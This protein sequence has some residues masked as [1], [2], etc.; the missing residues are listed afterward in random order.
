VAIHIELLSSRHLR[1]PFD[2]GESALN[3]FLRRQAGQQQRRGFGKTYVATDG[4]D[5]TVIGF[6]TVSAGQVATERLP[7]ALKLPRYPAPV[8]RIG[9]LAV[10]LRH[11]GQGIGR[12][13]LAFALRLALDF[14]QQIGLYAVLVDAKH[15]KARAYYTTLGFRPVGDDPLCLFLPLAT[16][17]QAVPQTFAVQ[18]P[19]P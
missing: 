12:H 2:C 1:D 10:D 19:R 15:D 4:T 9:R 18:E 3:D 8:L 16:L 13:L 17:A 5:A 6:I 11:Q 14:S 7:L